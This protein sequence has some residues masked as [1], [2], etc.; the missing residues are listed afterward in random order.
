MDG[1]IIYK[2]IYSW[3]EFFN[4]LNFFII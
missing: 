4:L 1:F 3:L 2:L